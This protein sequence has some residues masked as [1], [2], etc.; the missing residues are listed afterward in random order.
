MLDY[1]S[2]DKH[3]KCLP[4]YGRMSIDDDTIEESDDNI[5]WYIIDTLQACADLCD[6]EQRCK[7][8][9]AYFNAF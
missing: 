4:T 3:S 8:K 2:S 9:I 7:G 6:S 5:L 1:T